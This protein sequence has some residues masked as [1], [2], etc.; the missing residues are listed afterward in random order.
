MNCSY[1]YFEIVGI[2]VQFLRMNNTQRSIGAFN[3][4]Q[5]LQSFLQAMHHHLAVG[6]YLGVSWN[7]CRT[8]QITKGS[9]VPL[10][11]RKH[12]QNPRQRYEQNKHKTTNICLKIIHMVFYYLARA[13][14]P[15]SSALIFPHTSLIILRSASVH[16]TIVES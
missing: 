9:K 3:I 16:A 7:S 11:P 13:C 8:R 2:H 15:I 10:G 12:G 1:T 6:S 14:G 4:I 5:V